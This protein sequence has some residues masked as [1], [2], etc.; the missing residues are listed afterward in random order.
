MIGRPARGRRFSGSRR[1]RLGDVTPKGR[2]RLDAVARYLQ[3]VANDDAVDAIGDDAAAWVVRRTRIHVER[4]PVFREHVE[5]TTWASGVGSRWAER[6]TSIEGAGGG[7]IEAEALW[8]HVD[9]ESGRPKVLPAGF[10]AQYGE[11]AGGRTVSARLHHPGVEVG[12]EHH[13]WPVRFADF[14]VMGHVN[15]AVYWAAVEEH[16]DLPA[17]ATVEMEY[18]GG[19]DR[20]HAP[21]VAVA[22]DVLWVVVAGAVEASA[23]LEGAAVYSRTP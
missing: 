7:R 22:R 11:A 15:N 14:D 1:V 3:D 2:L 21:E 20:G 6:R 13:P 9:L 17:G 10:H 8:V 23:R 18:R 5:L 19:I 16:L 4:F 12:A